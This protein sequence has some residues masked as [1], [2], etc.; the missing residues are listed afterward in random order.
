M[1]TSLEHLP[2]GKRREIAFVVEAV[3]ALSLR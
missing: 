2:E 3:R 1:K